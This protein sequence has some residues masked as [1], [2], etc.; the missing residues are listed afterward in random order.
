MSKSSPLVSIIVPTYQRE[1]M[2]E[3]LMSSLPDRSDIELIFIDDH[4]PTPPEPHVPLDNVDVR[5]LTN[6]PDQKFAGTARNVGLDAARGDW[7]MFMDSDDQVNSTAFGRILDQV[8]ALKETDMVLFY[9]DSF[10]CG[11]AP[12]V[13][14]HATNW[15]TS[16]MAATGDSIY[17]AHYAPPWGR[18]I[19]RS[20]L[21][22]HGLR[23]DAV[24]YSNDV[25]F[26]ARLFV[27]EPR[28]VV[29]PDVA[30]RI[31]Q[32]HESL[33]S[34]VSVDAI[35]MRIDVLCE[36]NDFYRENGYKAMRLPLW[37]QLHKI[38]KRDRAGGIRAM[39][40]FWKAGQPVFVTP[41]TLKRL[42]LKM[43]DKKLGRFPM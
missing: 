35:H 5:F 37:V 19:S 6:L 7:V 36:M 15:I 24:K 17:L 39:L 9:S 8:P 22:E 3:E 42:L 20:F 29:L 1:K 2:L 41:Y 18:L 25:M 26:S 13:R 27:A 32:G 30:Y 21:K 34:E 10:E 11:G 43:V 23:F 4:S 16:K 28:F 12:G 33:T 40:K 31:R 38:M 14:H